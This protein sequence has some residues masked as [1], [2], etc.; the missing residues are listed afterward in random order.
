MH[1]TQPY[2]L[3][4]QCNVHNGTLPPNLMKFIPPL[5]LYIYFLYG[6]T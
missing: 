1:L 4:A 3:S 2:S 5:P 6:V